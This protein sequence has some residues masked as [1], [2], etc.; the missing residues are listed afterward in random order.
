MSERDPSEPVSA[1]GTGSSHARGNRTAA[2][3]SLLDFVTRMVT[4]LK[5]ADIGSLE[6]RLKRQNLP[7]D[8]SHLA[9]ATMRDIV[10]PGLADRLA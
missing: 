7:G 9:K 3:G 4:R 5:A 6:L 10:S 2:L 1:H 8:V